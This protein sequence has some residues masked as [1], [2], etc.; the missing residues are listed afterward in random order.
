MKVDA[1]I[2]DKDGTLIDFDAFWVT[3]SVKSL[4]EILKAVGMEDISIEYLLTEL[5]VH[6]GV[7]DI[8]GVLC[9]GTYK[10]MGKIIHKALVEKGCDISLSKVE[11][12]VVDA[13]NENSAVGEVIPTC[14]NLKEIL[15]EF[16]NSNIKLAVVTTDN[17]YITRQCLKKLGVEELFDKIYTDDGKTPA[18]PNPYCALNFCEF[19]GVAREHTVM[20][21]DTLTDV[22]FAKNAGIS[23]IG[24]AKNERNKNILALYTDIVLS[25]I[26]DLPSVLGKGSL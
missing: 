16:K 6:N 11:K 3:V 2:F 5:G 22:E 7:T 15:T 9:K 24:L 4:Q 1:I 14:P 20:V 21:G 12:L 13:Y 18:K 19:C 10:Q 26:S 23:M 17:E 8:N 25:K